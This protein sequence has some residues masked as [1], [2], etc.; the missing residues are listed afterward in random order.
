MGWT[1]TE[2]SPTYRSSPFG[3]DWT[4]NFDRIY[5]LG[6][7]G[8]IFVWAG[9]T[10]L[11]FEATTMDWI[12]LDL[13]LW[14]RLEFWRTLER[15]KCVQIVQVCLISS[16]IP[17]VSIIHINSRCPFQV[18]PYVR[19]ND[20]VAKSMTKSIC[21]LWAGL[22][23]WI[24]LGWTNCFR[25][26]YGPRLVG[27]KLPWSGWV[28]L[29][30]I[31]LRMDPHGLDIFLSGLDWMGFWKTEWASYL[32]PLRLRKGKPQ[33]Q[34]RSLSYRPLLQGLVAIWW[35][36][37]ILLAAMQWSLEGAIYDMWWALPCF[38]IRLYLKVARIGYP[39]GSYGHKNCGGFHLHQESSSL[40]GNLW[41]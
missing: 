27:F 36:H 18:S 19:N 31:E 20:L 1:F 30:W 23:V 16:Q 29:I 8:Q 24:G 2:S 38:S 22:W 12:G 11:L 25:K 32:W 37:M 35:S 9:Q 5:G 17:C 33:H 4:Q 21:R 39:A 14:M 26:F 15:Q 3:P 28:G 13:I 41:W 10:W 7:D 40:R 6:L 34:R